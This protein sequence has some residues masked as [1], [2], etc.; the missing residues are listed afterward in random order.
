MDLEVR[1]N[2]NTK[3]HANEKVVIKL[4]ALVHEEAEDEEGKRRRRRRR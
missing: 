2:R 1:P 3:A 4:V